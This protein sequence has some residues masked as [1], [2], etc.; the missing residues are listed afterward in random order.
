LRGIEAELDSRL[1]G[2]ESEVREKVADLLLAGIDDGPRR[3]GVD[4]SGY[5]LTKGL[6]A[7]TQLFQEDVGGQG[8]FGGHGLLR[9]DKETAIAPGL[10]SRAFLLT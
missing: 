1:I 5:I 3:G 7:A 4:G 8:R 2:S 6:E 9:F 10:L